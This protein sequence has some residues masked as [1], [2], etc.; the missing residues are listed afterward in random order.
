LLQMRCNGRDP[1]RQQ[2]EH[3]EP[4]NDAASFR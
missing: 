2:F 3:Q 4:F 1:I